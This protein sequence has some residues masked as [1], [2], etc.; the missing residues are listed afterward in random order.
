MGT[1]AVNHV[2]ESHFEKLLYGNVRKR[3]GASD[4]IIYKHYKHN[5]IACWKCSSIKEAHSQC[6]Y[7]FVRLSFMLRHLT[8]SKIFLA[9]PYF[10]YYTCSSKMISKSNLGTLSFSQACSKMKNMSIVSVRKHSPLFNHNDSN[11]ENRTWKL[12]AEVFR[13]VAA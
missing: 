4:C 1:S 5:E 13:W 7:L 10:F 9:V 8:I 12:R 2:I 11:N 6:L 3:K